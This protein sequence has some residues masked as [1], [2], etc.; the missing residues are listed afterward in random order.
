MLQTDGPNRLLP[1][2]PPSTTP[3]PKVTV[4]CCDDYCD[5]DQRCP[6]CGRRKRT[7]LPWS[8]PSAPWWQPSYRPPVHY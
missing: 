5:C 8:Y 7:S 4:G 6:R 3:D 2:P 1:D